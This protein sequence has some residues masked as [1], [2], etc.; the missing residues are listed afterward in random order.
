MKTRKR[1]VICASRPDQPRHHQWRW[2]V[3][4][5]NSAT[6]WIQSGLVGL[7][8]TLQKRATMEDARW[9][10][11]QRQLNLESLVIVAVITVFGIICWANAMKR[12]DAS[13]G[14]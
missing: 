6:F 8:A 12:H 10:W 3:V 2:L 14:H 7:A 4:L 11:H 1:V 5:A 13:S 9:V